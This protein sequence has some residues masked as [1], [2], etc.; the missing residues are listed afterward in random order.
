MGETQG[1]VLNK[2][3]QHPH[4]KDIVIATSQDGTKNCQNKH[5]LRL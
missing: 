1:T 5:V 2:Y 3:Y 4:V